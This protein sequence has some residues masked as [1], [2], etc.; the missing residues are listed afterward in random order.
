MYFTI[1]YKVTYTNSVCSE[2]MDVQDIRARRLAK[3]SAGRKLE[4]FQQSVSQSNN[5]TITKP[6]AA[7]HT[8][9]KATSEVREQHLIS[10]VKNTNIN[11]I[12]SRSSN[13]EL[14]N[15]QGSLRRRQSNIS[16]NN[17][18][19]QDQQRVDL[20]IES[21]REAASEKEVP[22]TAIQHK[23]FQSIQSEV[24]ISKAEQVQCSDENILDELPDL[25]AT[26]QKK[27]CSRTDC[28]CRR[29]NIPETNDVL[30]TTVTSDGSQEVS[31]ECDGKKP[32]NEAPAGQSTVFLLP[33]E[34]NLCW[35]SHDH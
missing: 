4:Q 21:S 31:R 17:S 28:N 13:I 11:G 32:L 1:S 25:L 9:D 14:C 22:I 23:E 10:N 34:K 33:I 7:N 5:S 26:T 12:I 35:L 2:G 19:V 6:S 20:S 27:K 3:L 16:R 8:E 18:N 15:T 24:N 30:V 29:K